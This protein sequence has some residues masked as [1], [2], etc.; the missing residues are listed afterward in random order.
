MKYLTSIL[1]ATLFSLGLTAQIS[2]EKYDIELKWDIDMLDEVPLPVATSSCGDVK[3]EI[4]DTMFSGGCLG[5]LSRTYVFTDDCGNKATAEQYINLLD[6]TP[7]VIHGVLAD[8]AVSKNEIPEVPEVTATDNSEKK[9]KISMTEVQ[10]DTEII[11]KW[12][13]IDNCGNTSEKEQII[14]ISSL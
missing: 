12:T 3:T 9:I 14:T 2:V 8:I 1:F 6:S 4:K 10:T 5:T 13:A 7:P 11:R